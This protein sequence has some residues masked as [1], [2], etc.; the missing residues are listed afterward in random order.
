M[1]TFLS[2]TSSTGLFRFCAC[3]QHPLLHIPFFFQELC[4]V[5]FFC[6]C[7]GITLEEGRECVSGCCSTGPSCSSRFDVN[8]VRQQHQPGGKEG[9]VER[10]STDVLML[11]AQ[12]GSFFILS[13]INPSELPPPP[14]RIVSCQQREPSWLVL[15]SELLTG[16]DH[17]WVV[18][19]V[20]SLHSVEARAHNISRQHAPTDELQRNEGILQVCER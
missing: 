3:H 8:I 19:P 2:T 20:D 15:F 6:L 4:R 16:K 9:H 17:V 10:G 14:T 18:K 1:T 7:N 13:S 11:D 12:A 5:D